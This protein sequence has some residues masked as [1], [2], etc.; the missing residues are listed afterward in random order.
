[1]LKRS[2]HNNIPVYRFTGLGSC[3]RL[4]HFIS[5]RE[6]GVSRGGQSSLNIGFTEEE[7]ERLAEQYHQNFDEVKRWYDGY[8]GYDQYTRTAFIPNEEIR[9]EL[10]MAVETQPWNEMLF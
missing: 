6:G 3:S 10:T 2:I 1:M 7:V 9:Q 8:L 4:V 5:G